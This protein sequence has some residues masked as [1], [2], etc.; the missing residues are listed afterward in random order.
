MAYQRVSPGVYR[1]TANNQQVRSVQNPGN[2]PPR[3][4]MIG[5]ARPIPPAPVQQPMAR[6]PG[7]MQ[8]PLPGASSQPPPGNWQPLSP[9]PYQQMPPGGQG[10]APWSAMGNRDPEFAQ[11]PW[12]GQQMQVGPNGQPMQSSAGANYAASQLASQAPPGN[13]Q[14]PGMNPNMV[15]SVFNGLA[16]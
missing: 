2:M 4:G 3:G 13:Q 7:I 16:R 11:S 1:N 8:A 14:A 15:N 5:G 12:G 6:P 9:Q 10:F